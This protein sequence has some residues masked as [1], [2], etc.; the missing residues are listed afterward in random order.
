MTTMKRGNTFHLRKRVPRRYQSVEECKSIWA[1]LHA[2]SE[3]VT[4]I[5]G[6]DCEHLV[7]A[8]EAR[9]AGDTTDDTN[10]RRGPSTVSTI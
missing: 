6:P 9:L 4:K 3:T 10:L 5:Q 2:D 1:S 8:W 7:E